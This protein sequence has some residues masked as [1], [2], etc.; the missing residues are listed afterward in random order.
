[1]THESR[2]E[3]IFRDILRE[4]GYY[5]DDN[6][7]IEEKKSDNPRIDKLL[8]TA[9]KSGNGYGYPEFIISFKNRTED[10]IV[11][12]CKKIHLFMKVKIEKVIRIMRLMGFYY[13]PHI[14]RKNIT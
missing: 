4:K 10:L 11:V 6:I 3:G 8:K 12:E 14:C 13:M 2:T 1:M 7:I 5:D 9:S